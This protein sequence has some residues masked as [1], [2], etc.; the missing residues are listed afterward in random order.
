MQTVVDRVGLALVTLLL[1]GTVA[2]AADPAEAKG[3]AIRGP[4]VDD[5]ARYQVEDGGPVVTVD[6]ERLPAI[7]FPDARG[8]IHLASPLRVHQVGADSETIWV[9]SLEDGRLLATARRDLPGAEAPADTSQFS[10]SYSP[11]GAPAHCLTAV[12]QA[13]LVDDGP[14]G[15]PEPCRLA[16]GDDGPALELDTSGHLSELSNDVVSWTGGPTR[17]TWDATSSFPAGIAFRSNGHTLQWTR[18]QAISSAQPFPKPDGLQPAPEIQQSA[19]VP[20]R[21]EDADVAHPFRLSTAYKWATIDP[22]FAKFQQWNR[23]QASTR[24][25]H[26]DLAVRPLQQGAELTWTIVVQ[27]EDSHA[28]LTPKAGIV[29]MSGAPVWRDFTTLLNPV[30]TTTIEDG[31]WVPGAGHFEGTPLP[32]LATL[33][34]Q[35]NAAFGDA[36][37][38][39]NAWGIDVAQLKGAQA[40]VALVTLRFDRAEW[41]TIAHN[42]AM[43]GMVERATLV[44]DEGGHLLQ[45]DVTASHDWLGGGMQAHATEDQAYL[46]AGA[47]RGFMLSPKE[48]AEAAA[49]LAAVLLAWRF[50]RTTAPVLALFARRSGEA[51][52]RTRILGIIRENPGIHF[53]GLV[54][55]AGAS[56]GTTTFH[57][58]VLRKRGVIRAEAH[59]GY[60]C[61]FTAD[62]PALRIDMVAAVKAQGAQAIV[63]ALQSVDKLT[64]ADLQRA[65]GLS[66]GTVGY[67]VKRMTHAGILEVAGRAYALSPAGRLLTDRGFQ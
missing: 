66:G 56:N 31:E 59:G 54:R 9:S 11:L 32:T 46:L 62:S 34:K 60:T 18:I 19:A 28:I 5:K 21:I 2:L 29:G 37:L 48:G 25:V 57:L 17:V 41:E 14:S 51:P 35:W 6:V 36:S 40:G 3:I 30:R 55:Q 8:T 64:R 16:T 7:R 15:L 43:T 63:E 23:T 22:A 27:G 42:P 49:L 50:L 65:T 44:L 4:H 47:Q 45:A 39:V 12:H 67:H 1:L 53:A 10:I 38:A 20:W 52:M 24:L 26:A 13:V 61:F 58:Q 33:Q